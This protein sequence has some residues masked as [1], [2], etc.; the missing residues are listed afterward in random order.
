CREKIGVER[1]DAIGPAEV[2]DRIHRLTDSRHRAGARVV[3]VH[4]LILM[5]LRLRKLRQNGFH[6]RREAWRGNRL[7]QKP[8]S[9]TL[10]RTL[11]VERGPKFTDKSCPGS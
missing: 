5:P 7:S 6:L 11:L 9:R 2:V 8:Y 10:L 1:E 4:R 3:V